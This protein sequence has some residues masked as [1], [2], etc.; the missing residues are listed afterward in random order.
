MLMSFGHHYLQL[1]G[2]SSPRP[3]GASSEAPS[4]DKEQMNHRKRMIILKFSQIQRLK[5]RCRLFYIYRVEI[6]SGGQ[7]IERSPRKTAPKGNRAVF[8]FLVEAVCSDG[9]GTGVVIWWFRIF[10]WLPRFQHTGRALYIAK[11]NVSRQLGLLKTLCLCF[12]SLY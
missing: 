6:L 9:W 3:L 2:P 11:W 12:S 1:Q 7:L 8:C 4:Q 10:S 5:Y